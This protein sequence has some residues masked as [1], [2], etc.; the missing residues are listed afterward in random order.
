MAYLSQAIQLLKLL[1]KAAWAFVLYSSGKKSAENKQLRG[2]NEA[3]EQL[4]DKRNDVA[5]NPTRNS[6]AMFK[7]LFGKD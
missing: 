7:R 2:E 4:N 6:G 3:H 1:S 5:D